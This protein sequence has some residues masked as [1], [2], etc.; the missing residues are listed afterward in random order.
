MNDTF[1]Q[2]AAKI[3]T[4]ARIDLICRQPF[5]GS[6]ALRLELVQ[7]RKL[8]PP[9]MA[10]NGR[11]I[12]YHPDFVTDC[13]N[14]SDGTRSFADV[15][16]IVAHEIGH[17]V[18][19]HMGRRNGRD[20]RKW[21]LAGDYV[22]NQILQDG[23]FVVPKGGLINPAYAGM[24]ADEVYNLIPDDPGQGQYD[25]VMDA[26]VGTGEDPQQHGA[27]A[28][29]PVDSQ[30]LADDWKLAVVQAANAAK[31]AGKLPGSLERFID[32]MTASKSDWRSRLKAFATEVAKNDYSYQR[33]NRKMLSAGYILPGL[34]S[35]SMGTMVVVTDDSGSIG[36]D[37]LQT[38]ANEIEAI[39]DAVHPERLIIIS[40]DAAVNHVDDLANDE[41]FKMQCHGGG[42]TNFRPPFEW[43]EEHGVLPACLIYLTDMYGPFPEAEP[44]FPVMWC[45]TTDV[46]GPWGQTLKVEMDS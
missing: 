36:N 31:N 22:V 44:P 6:L 4:Q 29:S 21:N 45:A 26:E 3:M 41:P 5:F 33:V 37:I 12:Y 15:V 10:T 43:L 18:F 40:C 42:G 39:R 34:F 2:E 11:F 1:S 38:F 35:E 9:T 46:V 20:P 32:K 25:N 27:N 30:A 24:S 13:V 23:G 19:D 16:F 14:G 7:T 8:N 28:S 17:C